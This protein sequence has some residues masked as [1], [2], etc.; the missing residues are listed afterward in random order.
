[1]RRALVR[2]S[3]CLAVAI[4]LLFP[5]MSAGTA[6]A[7]K[8]GGVPLRVELDGTSG[9]GGDGLNVYVDGDDCNGTI[10]LRVRL[11]SGGKT[12]AFDTRN[13]LRAV[14]VSGALLECFDPEGCE[15]SLQAEFP[16]NL[17]GLLEVHIK[18]GVAKFWFN[19]AGVDW[20][21][22][23]RSVSVSEEQ[24]NGARVWTVESIPDR[25]GNHVAGLSRLNGKRTKPP[26]TFTGNYNS[27]LLLVVTDQL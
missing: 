7:Q 27:H 1:M 24:V 6:E 3:W 5:G 9:F 18:D 26:E 23:W 8:G 22:D 19:T 21:I 15:G 17:Q 11:I 16:G 10:C 20:R 14:T 13:T 25:D 2:S 12:I 4:A